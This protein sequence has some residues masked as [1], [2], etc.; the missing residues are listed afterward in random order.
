[1]HYW[2]LRPQGYGHAEDRKWEDILSE[3]ATTL[4]AKVLKSS[5]RS[6]V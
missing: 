6:S 3:A 2:E 4:G 1:M 5:L